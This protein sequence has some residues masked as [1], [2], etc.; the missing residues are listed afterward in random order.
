MGTGIRSFFFMILFCHD[1]VSF[2]RFWN[3]PRWQRAKKPWR[4]QAKS[5]GR[6][7]AKAQSWLISVPYPKIRGRIS[8]FAAATPRLKR[9]A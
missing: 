2:P 8:S 9:T 7:N 3:S 1:S 4:S 6:F 5:Q